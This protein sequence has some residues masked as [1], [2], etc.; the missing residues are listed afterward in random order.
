M[1]GKTLDEAQYSCAKKSLAG[2]GLQPGQYR[3]SALVGTV[4]QSFDLRGGGKKKQK[5]GGRI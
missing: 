4:L 2:I 1:S 3:Y 5:I